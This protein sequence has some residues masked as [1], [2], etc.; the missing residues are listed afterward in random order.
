M[1]PASVNEPELSTEIFD[2]QT[3]SDQAEHIIFGG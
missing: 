2:R 1:A 3:V